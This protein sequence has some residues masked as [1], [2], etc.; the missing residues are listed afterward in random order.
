M[1]SSEFGILDDGELKHLG[2]AVAREYLRR[3]ESR[4]DLTQGSC[5]LFPGC[6][7]NINC[8]PTDPVYKEALKKASIWHV[9]E[10]Y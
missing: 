5:R 10:A 7:C 6:G 3:I 4:T 2:T 9:E 1:T 8:Q